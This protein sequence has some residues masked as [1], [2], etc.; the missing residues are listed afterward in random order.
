[1]NR[2]I[3]LRRSRTPLGRQYCARPCCWPIT[4]RTTWAN[5]SCCGGCLGRGSRDQI[6]TAFPAAEYSGVI[7]ACAFCECNEIRDELLHKRWDEIPT[8]FIDL[9]SSPTLP[10]PEAFQAFLPA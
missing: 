1:M 3:C 7:T 4:T 6:S 9:T 10:T 2:R 8:P 5:W